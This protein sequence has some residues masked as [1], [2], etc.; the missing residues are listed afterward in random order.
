MVK[1]EKNKNGN[2]GNSTRLIAFSL[3]VLFF[4]F[5]LLSVALAQKQITFSF[6]PPDGTSFTETCRHTKSLTAEGLGQPEVQVLEEKAKYLIQKTEAG[7]SVIV[8][9]LVS[10]L[11]S[12]EGMEGVMRSLLSVA[13][14]TYSLDDQGRL[15][16]V[17]GVEGMMRA[18]KQNLPE[19]LYEALLAM[20]EQLGKTPM[21]FIAESWQKK[22]V[23][24]LLIG[25]TAQVDHIYSTTGQFPL[26]DGAK[27]L[28]TNRLV[29]SWPVPFKGR[30][31]AR[32]EGLVE[33]GDEAVGRF[34]TQLLRGMFIMVAKEFD[35]S[36][37]IDEKI[38]HFEVSSSKITQGQ[39]QILDPTTGLIY[40]NTSMLTYQGF[41]GIKGEP[42]AKFE[43]KEIFECSYTYP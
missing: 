16:Q 35:P 8:T 40:S 37:D 3:V 13:T 42:K 43:N 25:R 2:L 12:S 24:G 4:I 15:S 7:Y 19:E 36:V 20:F 18:L 1:H 30:R 5:G 6:N 14:L 32:V 27:A 34:L 21:Q 29:I 26:P 41:F 28:T 31:C 23:F 9:P 33:S 17:Q 39:N 11:K 10:S 38:P 22:A